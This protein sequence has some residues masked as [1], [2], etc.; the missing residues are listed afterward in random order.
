MKQTLT[1]SVST[2]ESTASKINLDAY[3]ESVDA[4]DAKNYLQSFHL[5]LDYI[6]AELR[7][8]YGNPEGTKF[9]IP[10]G[11]LVVNI[12][13]E[14]EELKITAPFLA[15]PEK[16]RIPLLRQVATLNFKELD[17]A[18]IILKDE[19]LQFEYACPLS[20]AHPFKVHYVLRE[21]CLLGDKYDD[22]FSSKFG[23]VRIYE[24]Q[25]TPYDAKTV[26]MVYDTI[27]LS[28]KECLEGTTYFENERKYGFAWN[29]VA[30][31]VLKILY[32]AH[33]QGQLLNDLNKTVK[34]LDRQ[35]IPLHEVTTIGKKM[36]E[37]IQGLSKEELAEELYYIETFV[38]PKRRSS[39]KNIQDN[40]EN[41]FKKVSTYIEQEDYMATCVMITYQF[42][43]MYF[44]NNVQDDVN[45]VVINALAQSSAKPWNEAA[46][47][48]YDAMDNIMEGDLT[49]AQDT[50]G[51]MDMNQYMAALQQSMQGL[52]M[53][54]MAQNIQNMMASMLG[55]NK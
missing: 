55:G 49:P 42:Y 29:V 46:Q 41:T 37:R 22:E 50:L 33:P 23:A 53:G 17:Q 32:Y 21:I 48:L 16:S 31:T 15:L 45:L 18:G 30:C 8:K 40:F 9:C 39:L 19:Q 26:D 38:S 54:D 12:N 24:P 44:Y 14:N 2:I 7:P 25:V 43:N 35:D 28:C 1:F 36:V 47:I 5:L 10:H 51:G 52:N 34:E 27:Q 4:Y 20:L 3:D 6:N 13:I 11:S